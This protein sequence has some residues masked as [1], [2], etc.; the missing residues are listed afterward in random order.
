MRVTSHTLAVGGLFLLAACQTLDAESDTPAVITNPTE[1][2]RVA[3]RST[4]AEIFAGR[5]V[6]VADDALTL[7]S[8]LVIEYGPR[9][10]IGTPPATGR[11][12][13]R[14]LEFNLVRNGADCI[15]IDL[16][17]LSRHVLA[18]TTC[19]PE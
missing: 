14:P 11:R 13:D 8:T 6:T 9:D 19:V 12:V 17:N 16:R 7:S 3:L 2:S 18:D 10:S 15:L 4:L 1:A 5:E